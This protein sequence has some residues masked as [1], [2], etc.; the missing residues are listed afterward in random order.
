MCRRSSGQCSSH[1]L[2]DSRVIVPKIASSEREVLGVKNVGEVTEVE[3]MMINVGFVMDDDRP[4]SIL[5]F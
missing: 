5:L 3:G 2:L 4:G 1:F